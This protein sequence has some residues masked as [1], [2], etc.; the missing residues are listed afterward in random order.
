MTPE[1]ISY[2]VA[3]LLVVAALLDMRTGKIPNWLAMAG[4]AIFIVK[5]AVFPDSVAI[6]PQMALAVGVLVGGFALFVAGAFGAGA[7]KLAFVTALFMP[8][9]DA[10]WL[11]SVLVAAIVVSLIVFGTLRVTMGGDESGWSV[12]RRRV[13]PLAVPIAATGL[14]GL[15]AF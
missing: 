4:V 9:G 1:L 12:L 11:L 3:S 10:L 6:W 14:T 2:G 5:L 15:F 8:V 13:I 7:V